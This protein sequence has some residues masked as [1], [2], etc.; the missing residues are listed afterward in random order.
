MK[1]KILKSGSTLIELVLVTGLVAILSALLATLVAQS[2]KSYRESRQIVELQGNAALAVR[3]FESITRG[4]TEIIT[5]APDELA[6]YAYMVGDDYP[7]PTLIR[8][9]TEN[10]ELL[11][12]TIAPVGEG[13]T[14]T[15]PPENELVNKIIRHVL[16]AD[17]IFRYYNEAS[18]EVV[19]PTPT[20]TVRMIRITINVGYTDKATPTDITETTVVS[21]RNLKNNL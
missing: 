15:Y 14:F 9:Y 10:G 20:D 13:P 5:S 4:A 2:L 21:L 8:Y 6:F 19:A 7:A 11:R 12:S 3:D 1:I 16:N 18:V 17:T